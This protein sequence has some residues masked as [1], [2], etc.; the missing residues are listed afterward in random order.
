MLNEK[1]YVKTHSADLHLALIYFFY[2]KKK[3]KKPFF[4]A[5]FTLNTGG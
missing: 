4:S 2:K 3:E 1:L 5:S